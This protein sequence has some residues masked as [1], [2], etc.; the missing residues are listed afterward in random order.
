MK[1]EDRRSMATCMEVLDEEYGE[2]D[3]DK[4]Y[5]RWIDFRVV[6]HLVAA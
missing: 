3:E 2:E 6:P 4:E 5:L 1:R